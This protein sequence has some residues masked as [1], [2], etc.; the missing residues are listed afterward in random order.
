MISFKKSLIGLFIII[1]IH[2]FSQDEGV[3]LY[4][5]N[6]HEL[7]KYKVVSA[8]KTAEDINEVPA[9]VRVVTQSEIEERGYFTLDELLADLPGFQFRDILSLN[10][11]VF[12]RGIPN[13]N[14]LT[15][16]LIDGIQVNELNSGGFY[17]GGQFNM[18]N[19]DRVEVVYGPSSVA[20]GT[21]AVSGV[22]N[23]ITKGD[24]KSIGSLKSQLG[25][26]N[27]V[28][29]DCSF[30]ISDKREKLKVK[31][32]GMFKRTEKSDLRG[33]NGDYNWSDL[34]D[35]FENDYNFGVKISFKDFVFG[36]NYLQKQTSTATLYKSYG[37]DYKDFGSFWNILFVNSY[38]KYSKRLNNNLSLTS[39]LYNRNSTVL[40]NTIY[41]ITDTSQVGY[42]R[43]NNLSGFET[44][45][46]YKGI[47]NLSLTGGI[48]IEF[49]SLADKPS[50][51]YSKSMLERPILPDKPEMHENYL[52]SFFCEPEY[53]LFKK[54]Y[55]YGGIRYDISSIYNQVL[56]PRAG[57]S[58]NIN[59]NFL[60]LTYAEAF[61]APKPWDYTDG[62]GNN[63]LLPEKLNSVEL[64]FIS[65]KLG[66][67][68]FESTG[69]Y[70]NLHNSLY[71]EISGKDYRWINKGEIY[72]SGLE[73]SLS[74]TD[75]KLRASVNYTYTDSKDDTGKNIPEISKHSGN[76]SFSY[77]FSNNLDFNIRGNFVGERENNYV[78]SSTNSK[79]IDPYFVLNGAINWSPVKDLSLQLIIKNIL[80]TEYYHTSNRAPER[81]RQPQRMMMISVGYKIL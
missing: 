60:K 34:I 15:L 61:R 73:T 78:I 22:I 65:Q 20:Y 40:K 48:T 50:M 36:T 80:N 30:N 4:D 3:D 58:Y 25:N 5:L 27:T 28:S 38:L 16:V 59:D 77:Y 18:S 72:I 47:K 7:I 55:I 6:I 67:F 44:L 53:L 21:N 74:Y 66:N 26:F 35:N 68:N 2:S 51:T 76:V 54:L 42:Y 31:I 41:Y 37:T 79:I 75:E 62:L 29:G 71:K 11:Y 17:S 33:A 10:S 70:S 69:Y 56:T 13:Q 49:E 57:I 23:I 43:P 39:T 24:D 8:T 46:N 52:L 19:I 64:S 45:I 9:T 32:T 63:N 12:Q 81:Y 14:N 1:S